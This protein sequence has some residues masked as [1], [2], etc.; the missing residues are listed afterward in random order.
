LSVIKGCIFDLDGTLLDTIVDIGE[1]LNIVLKKYNLPVHDMEAYKTFVGSGTDILIKR[2]TKSE[3]NELNDAIL[4]EYLTIYHQNLVS[5][6]TVYKNVDNTLKILNEKN[7]KIAVLTNKPDKSAKIMINTYF[8]NIKFDEILGQSENFPIKPNP[9]SAVHLA[10]NIMRLNT[11]NIAFIG[12]SPEDMQ[13]ANNAKMLPI[14][15]SW[16]YQKIEKLLENNAKFIID[17]MSELLGI[18]GI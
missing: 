12:D 7:I 2:A 18:I 16:G 4:S 3:K 6:T 15:V 1:S 14:G 11:E 17:N 9:A 13:T 10:K 8:Q 5:K